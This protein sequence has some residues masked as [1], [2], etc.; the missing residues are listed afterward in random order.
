MPRCEYTDCNRKANRYK[1]LCCC[2]KLF[3]NYHKFFDLHS[4]THDWLT[5]N[6]KL[7]AKQNPKVKSNKGLEKLD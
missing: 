4:C 5:V 6:R 1:L 2:R 3:C 7:L